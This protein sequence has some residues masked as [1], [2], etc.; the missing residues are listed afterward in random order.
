MSKFKHLAIESKQPETHRL[1]PANEGIADS[2]TNMF[3][4]PHRSL[5]D[6]G[7]RQGLV[8]GQYKSFV[9]DY[10]DKTLRN[11][12]WVGR[13]LPLGKKTMVKDSRV[14]FIDGQQ[15][16]N[17]TDLLEGLERMLAAAHNVVNV[18]ASNI[19]DRKEMSEK[20]HAISTEKDDPE[21]E[22][23]QLYKE[24]AKKFPK[25]PGQYYVSKG[26]KNIKGV[27]AF[28][29][30]YSWPVSN[31]LFMPAPDTPPSGCS[32]MAPTSSTVDEYARVIERLVDIVLEANTAID[33][34][35]I[36]SWRY[37][38]VDPDR[39]PAKNFIFESIFAS[40]VSD[41]LTPMAFTE[42]VA[43]QLLIEMLKAI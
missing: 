40:A 25:V 21:E 37:L 42:R 36:V 35:R 14:S 9:K 29:D 4:P 12:K 28:D 16:G 13:N 26:G 32:I 8:N 41:P 31:G 3:T 10:L 20:M 18:M 24:N 17:P 19:R 7:V 5:D 30:R 22:I 2:I 39:L 34:N 6:T 38:E 27:V 11:S 23:M 15:N 43:Q 33:K 1:V